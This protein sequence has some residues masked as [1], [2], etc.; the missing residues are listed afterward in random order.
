MHLRKYNS[1]PQNMY[2]IKFNTACIIFDKLNDAN[3]C[4]DRMEK[5]D[6]EEKEKLSVFIEERS[7][8]SEG[9]ITD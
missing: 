4:L 8:K 6:K 9:V 3:D 2:M 7:T 5:R 1:A